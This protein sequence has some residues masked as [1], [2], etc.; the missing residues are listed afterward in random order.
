MSPQDVQAD[1]WVCPYGPFT[2]HCSLLTDVGA[3]T[4]VSPYGRGGILKILGGI[5]VGNIY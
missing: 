5:P 3:D 4:W 2:V 1:T